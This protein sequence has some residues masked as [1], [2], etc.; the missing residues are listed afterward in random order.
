MKKVFWKDKDGKK[1]LVD[2]MSEDYAK[3]VLKMLIRKN[4]KVADKAYRDGK[5]GLFL[6]LKI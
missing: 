3:N 1:V 4:N 6:A 2:D 5:L